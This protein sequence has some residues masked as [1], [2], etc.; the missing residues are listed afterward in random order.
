MTQKFFV[1]IFCCLL[2][3][4]SSLWDFLSFPINFFFLSVCSFSLDFLNILIGSRNFLLLF[5]F[6]K[7][8]NFSVFPEFQDVLSF[9]FASQELSK[10]ELKSTCFISISYKKIF[11]CYLIQGCRVISYSYRKRKCFEALS[12]FLCQ[13]FSFYFMRLSV[14]PF[15]SDVF[16]LL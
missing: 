6:F 7:N 13:W 9:P 15:S 11:L 8:E 12:L 16:K 1:F 4:F 10:N 3:S 14:F 2:F 5:H